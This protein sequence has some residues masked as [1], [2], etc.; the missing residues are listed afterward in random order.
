[1]NLT[2]ADTNYNP[3]YDTAY[4]KGNYSLQFGIQEVKADSGKLISDS[5][6]GIWHSPVTWDGWSSSISDTAEYLYRYSA[7]PI[8]KIIS[9]SLYGFCF[10]FDSLV[11]TKD[12]GL[13][14]AYSSISK[15]PNVPYYYSWQATLVNYNITGINK[16]NSTEI[17][18]DYSLFQNYP[19]P[20]NPTTVINYQIPKDGFVSLK[21][22]DL[23]GKEV[24]TLISGHKNP[25]SYSANFDA[26]NLASGIYFYRLRAGNFIST[27]KMMLLK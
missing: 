21:V 26:S 5:Y 23:L 25:G 6:I 10:Y 9:N 8:T 2:G 11:F 12:V 27:K 24:K 1:M 19:N 14:K 16:N 15:G 4:S 20:F 3:I 18:K 13:V 17:I 22:Y 7:N